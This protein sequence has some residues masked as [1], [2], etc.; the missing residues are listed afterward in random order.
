MKF[1]NLLEREYNFSLKIKGWHIV[2]ILLSLI[3]V[4]YTAW[5]IF[6]Y[7]RVGNIAIKWHTWFAVTFLSVVLLLIPEKPFIQFK[8]FYL[9]FV[10]YVVLSLAI[11]EVHPFTKVPMYSSFQEKITIFSLQDTSGNLLPFNKYSNLSTGP[12]MHKYFNAVEIYKNTNSQQEA[13]KKAIQYL[14]AEL[15]LSDSK[16]HNLNLYRNEIFIAGDSIKINTIKANQ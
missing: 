11:G 3:Y 2:L 5:E 16:N 7:L 12:L 4:P 10:M 6:W 1:E 13:E 14:D 9:L 15:K 8:K